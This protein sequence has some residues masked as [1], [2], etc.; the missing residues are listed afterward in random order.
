M[1]KKTDEEEN[2]AFLEEEYFKFEDLIFGEEMFF[3]NFK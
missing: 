2:E 1:K 3:E